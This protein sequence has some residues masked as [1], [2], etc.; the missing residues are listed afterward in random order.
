MQSQATA[1]PIRTQDETVGAPATPRL[2]VARQDSDGIAGPLI[3]AL[4]RAWT[5]IRRNHPELPPAVFITGSGCEPGRSDML[6]L[7]HFAAS[8]W[9]GSDGELDEIFVGGEGLER[10]ARAVFATELH[11]GVHCLARVRGIQDTSRQGRYH[12][13]RFKALAEEVGL[14]IDRHP[15][16][17]WSLTTLPEATAHRYAAV[18]EDLEQA[19]TIFRCHEGSGGSEA[20][21]KPGPLPC[22]CS[23]IPVRRI[24]VAPAVLAIGPILCGVCGHP[25]EADT[26]TDDEA[27]TGEEGTR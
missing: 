2:T 6:R 16:I 1:A 15:V 17:G 11:E 21:R 24:R 23:C 19:I 18:I 26:P 5:A 4:E 14:E 25:F 7:G 8:R 20:T 9:T 3:T 13:M 22:L 10:G 12:N 27:T